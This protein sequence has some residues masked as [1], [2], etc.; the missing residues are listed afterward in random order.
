M[1][2]KKKLWLLTAPFILTLI[3]CG[4]TSESEPA[5]TAA[6]DVT[7][8][9]TPAT[10]DTVAPATGDT[11][12]AA[13]VVEVESVTIK[14]GATA[15]VLEKETL[16]LAAEVLPSNAT[17]KNV[18]WSIAEGTAGTVDATGLFTA[19]SVDNDE[20]VTVKAVAG[21][22]ETTIEIT[23]QNNL[24]GF[25]V[26]KVGTEEGKTGPI[27]D[28]V[29]TA[30][31]NITNPNYMSN[32]L[33]GNAAEEI[34]ATDAY[35][36]SA[37]L[38]TETAAPVTLVSAEKDEI[39]IGFVPYYVDDDNY[40]VAYV[41]WATY[42]KDGWCREFQLT[43]MINGTSVGYND[44]WLEGIQVNPALGIDLSV[45]RIGNQFKFDM[46]YNTTEKA[47]K[48]VTISGLNDSKTSKVGFYA[49]DSHNGKVSYTNAK[50]EKYV[51]TNGYE[52]SDGSSTVTENGDGSLT[53]APV[54][55][56]W[57]AGFAL[58]SFERLTGMTKYSMSAHVVT[59]GAAPFTDEAYFGFI[60][61][62]ED[63]NNFLMVYA[64]YTG[65]RPNGRCLQ[66]TGQINGVDTGWAADKWT[67]GTPTNPAN[68]FDFKIVRD[69]GNFSVT[70][71]QG[72]TVIET[73]WDMSSKLDSTK[74]TAK[75]G[76]WG[77]GAIGT[78]TIS[79][80]VISA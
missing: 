58:K 38:V 27:Y 68:G 24:K 70:M 46:T 7:E 74:T 73:T 55:S 14:N 57:K 35:T 2:N 6:P 44:M 69:G 79:D 72:E 15:T 28:V 8:T 49:Y 12:T 32:F 39:Q 13:P 5:T 45:R 23:V 63:N 76:F 36:M 64:Q 41:E 16:Q 9:V 19:G 18:T 54:T 25:E 67:D 50:V 42:D 78:I 61:Y 10:S 4:N 40:I 47:S 80:I 3:G 60:P 33:V 51:E 29:D 20:T 48:S 22:K 1:K 52:I 66:C 75:V 77:S 11:E 30:N 31:V 17:D 43:G 37:H 21:G 59:T 26:A 56:N 53:Y 62:Y 34:K 71:T 65:D